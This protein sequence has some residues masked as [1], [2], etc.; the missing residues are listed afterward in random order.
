[1]RASI[2]I[3]IA[4]FALGGCL[5]AAGWDPREPLVAETP[6]APSG[7]TSIMATRRAGAARWSADDLEDLGGALIPEAT[8]Y[9]IWW[10]EASRF[11]ADAMSGMDTFLSG[12]DGSRY[13]AVVDQ[14]VRQPARAIFA[15]HLMETSPSPTHSPSSEEIVAKVCQVLADARQTPS[16]TA[17]YLVFTDGF[18]EPADFCA[19]HDGGR[20]PDGKRIHVA[21]L[22][23]MANAPQCDPGDLF[24]CNSLSEPT[25]ALANVTAHETI[26][27]LTDPDGT[28]WLDRS[29]DEIADK[30]NFRFG[31]CVALGSTRWQLQKQWSNADRGCVQ[32]KASASQG[33]AVAR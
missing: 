13:L 11:P 10:G 19:W 30:C 26:E 28:G 3:P 15:G 27:M 6:V 22:P 32:E 17:L 33:V 31:S 9:A 16:P 29:G 4:S 18:P 14:Y 23:N 5:G 12:L 24:H 25:R 2:C 7:H 1:M 21:Y 8:V 20:C